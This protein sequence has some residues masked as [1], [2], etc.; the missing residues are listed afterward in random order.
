MNFQAS[1]TIFNSA[2]SDFFYS[3]QALPS[4]VAR[5]LRAWILLLLRLVDGYF[6]QGSQYSLILDNRGHLAP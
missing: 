4:G 6:N 1:A 2:S 5:N 3:S